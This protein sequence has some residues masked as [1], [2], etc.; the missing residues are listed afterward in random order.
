MNGKPEALPMLLI[1]AIRYAFAAG[2]MLLCF[3]CLLVP[4]IA[5]GLPSQLS[6]KLKNTI[7][8]LPPKTQ[9][10]MV[11]DLP[12]FL[13]I[14]LV[15]K[16]T[17][18]SQ[19]TAS[20]LLPYLKSNIRFVVLAVSDPS[21]PIGGSIFYGKID[22]KKWFEFLKN[23]RFT[24]KKINGM[25]VFIKDKSYVTF[26]NTSHVVAGDKSFVQ[27]T[28][29]VFAKTERGLSEKSE[30]WKWL[31]K[32]DGKALIRGAMTWS[33]QQKEQMVR[34]DFRLG[35]LKPV[36]AI[37]FSV[38]C[39]PSVL[40]LE[41]KAITSS[42][43]TAAQLA[44]SLALWKTM[45]GNLFAQDQEIQHFLK[46]VTISPL[47][48]NVKLLAIFAHDDQTVTHFVKKWLEP[49]FLIP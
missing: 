32:T 27:S 18:A 28:I 25:R 47:K 37:L 13:S 44:D 19:A 35:L 14:P 40:E 15:K 3:V 30:L 38:R 39:S 33:A 12:Q 42:A 11:L 41:T 20:E 21:K 29:N 34:T 2:G 45:A 1:A 48:N 22:S 4:T 17:F 46:A 43:L 7:K 36:Q 31:D 10:V 8:L 49:L 16:S 5:A 9:A 6:S 26:L 24:E 23:S